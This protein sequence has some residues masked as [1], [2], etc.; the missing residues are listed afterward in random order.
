MDDGDETESA[1]EQIPNSESSGDQT[2][3]NDF[4]NNN[5][6]DGESSEDQTHDN[7]GDDG[8][9]DDYDDGED[10]PPLRPVPGM[11]CPTYTY[12]P[13]LRCRPAPADRLAG[14]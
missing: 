10:F 13:L 11:P 7:N 6:D 1:E 12:C 8:N 4:D 5:G 9:G 2:R 14:V 3:D